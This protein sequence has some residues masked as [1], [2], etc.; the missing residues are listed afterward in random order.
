MAIF[1][2]ILGADSTSLELDPVHRTL[3]SKSADPDCPRDV[4]C[5]LHRYT[6]KEIILRRAW[7]HGNVNFDGA[8]IIVP[9]RALLRLIVELAKRKGFTY[10]WGYALAVTLRKAMAF[11]TLHT[12]AD[13]PALFLFLETYPVCVPDWLAI[14]PRQMGRSGSTYHRSAQLPRLQRSSRRSQAPHTDVTREA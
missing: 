1:R 6:H 8:I 9:P 13:L 11:F 3:G 7:E 5:W 4:L 10:R 12:Q 14:L 2:D